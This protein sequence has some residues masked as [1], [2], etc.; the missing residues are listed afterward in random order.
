MSELVI[1][2]KIKKRAS[3][4]LFYASGV[5]SPAAT[6]QL[7][8]NYQFSAR[9][10]RETSVQLNRTQERKFFIIIKIH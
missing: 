7:L 8:E 4:T 6:V 1:H 2:I 3:A 10:L 9:S 5:Y